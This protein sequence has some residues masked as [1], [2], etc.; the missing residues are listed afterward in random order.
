MSM[1]AKCATLTLLVV[2]LTQPSA[3]ASDIAEPVRLGTM[4][5][6]RHGDHGTPVILIPGLAS[7]GWVWDDAVRRLQADHVVYV[8]TLAGFDGIAPVQGKLM[9]LADDSLVELIG[10]QHIDRPVL[11][12]HS[13]G[14][15]LSI[16]FAERHS[17]LIAGVVAVDGLPVFPGFERMPAE[18]R[19]A[20]GENIRA[21][22]AGGTPEQVAAQQLQYMKSIGVLDETSAAELAKRMSRSDPAATAQYMAEDLAL[23]LR[24]DLPSIK[25]PLLEICPFNA[26]DVP[27]TRAMT[28]AD[29][30]AYYRELLKGAPNV[31]VISISPARHFV[32]IDQPEAFAK[33]LN[34]F[35]GAAPGKATTSPMTRPVSSAK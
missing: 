12:G 25:V 18:Q 1:M 21:R 9:D 31:E 26:A 15:T 10:T 22:M 30:A 8:V 5:A 4:T 17:E 16:R 23:D 11:V 20:M 13:L 6:Q 34:Q 3:A 19:T 14:G 33:A 29:K 7:G 2:A 24:P 27:K 35:L 32:M 28:E